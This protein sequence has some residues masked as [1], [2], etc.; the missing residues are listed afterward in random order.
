[1]KADSGRGSTSRDTTRVLLVDG[2]RIGAQLL[3]AALE[4]EHDLE[5]VGVAEDFTAAVLEALRLQ[6]DVVLVVGLHLELDDWSA[7][8]VALAQ[9][10]PTSRVV[11]LVPTG[12]E[13]AFDPAEHER[14]CVVSAQEA[15]LASLLAALRDASR[16]VGAAPQV[17]R[18]GGTDSSE[19]RGADLVPADLALLRLVAAGFDSESSARELQIS[20]GLVRQ[21][22]RRIC[23]DLGVD[24]PTQA[25]AVAVASRLLTLHP[26]A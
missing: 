20:P 9:A 19:V 8:R 6:P 1:M 21:R 23:T 2:S 10:C 5:C 7:A 14:V 3:S 4:D 22:L 15:D 25:V 16:G 12:S 18:A 24:T 17:S 13:R 11:M 26:Q